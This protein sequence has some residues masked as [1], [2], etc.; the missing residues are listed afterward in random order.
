M[1][2]KLT[3]KQLLAVL[4]SIS[5]VVMTALTHL[6]VMNVAAE[7]N[8]IANTRKLTSDDFNVYIDPESADVWN[9]KDGMF[10]GA[11]FAIPQSV[12]S[13][14]N[15]TIELKT[16]VAIANFQM[17]PNAT[18]KF[19]DSIAFGAGN[20]LEEAKANVLGDGFGPNG[21]S[22]LVSNPSSVLSGGWAEFKFDR[23]L[24]QK[25]INMK[26]TFSGEYFH[27]NMAGILGYDLDQLGSN[28]VKPDSAKSS[29]YGSN[30]SVDALISE[31]GGG[32]AESA[33][34]QLEFDF[35]KVVNIN[36]VHLDFWTNYEGVP[37]DYV[38]YTSNNGTDYTKAA[39]LLG[40]RPVQPAE[41]GITLSFD[42]VQ[43]QYLKLELA[44]PSDG[45]SNVN[46]TKVRFYGGTG[47]PIIPPTEVKARKLTSADFELTASTNTW[48]VS[49]LVDSTGWWLASGVENVDFTIHLKKNIAVTK[50]K[51]TNGMDHSFPTQIQ[52]NVGYDA[53]CTGA[54]GY[55]MPK[56]PDE[57]NGSATISNTL[58]AAGY[59]YNFSTPVA[60]P[61]INLYMMNC[62]NSGGYGTA[63][64][65]SFELYGYDI[66]DVAGETVT[67]Y[68]ATADHVDSNF[69]AQNLLTGSSMFSSGS[70]GDNTVNID[71]D[72]AKSISLVGLKLIGRGDYVHFPT[73]YQLYVSDNGVDYVAAGGAYLGYKQL[74]P[75]TNM[76]TQI[77]FKETINTRYLRVK[78]SN[79][80]SS[81]NT[82]DLVKAEFYQAVSDTSSHDRIENTHISVSGDATAEH[83]L[84]NLL[85]GDINS[86]WSSTEGSEEKIFDLALDGQYVIYDVLLT[87]EAAAFPK[88]IK[89]QYK[90]SEDEDYSNVK[91]DAAFE[92]ISGPLKGVAKAFKFTYKSRPT[93]VAAKYLR[94]IVSGG[95]DGETAVNYL[96]ELEL[97]GYPLTVA[98][99]SKIPVASCVAE[100]SSQPEFNGDKLI[101]GSTGNFWESGQ[102]PSVQPTLTFK[103]D[104]RYHV[105]AIRLFGR[106]DFYGFAEKIKVQ[107]STD[108]KKF[109]D[110]PGAEYDLIQH[111][112]DAI[113]VTILLP[114]DEASQKL[115]DTT[116][117]RIV[118]LT[119]STRDSCAQFTEVELYGTESTTETPVTSEGVDVRKITASS[120]KDGTSL[121]GL[122]DADLSTYWS[123]ADG[124]VKPSVTYL[125][126]GYH[127]LSSLKIYARDGGS[128]A[129]FS[130]NYLIEYSLDGGETFVEAS[131]TKTEGANVVTLN[132]NFRA[133][134]IRITV[135]DETAAA[136]EIGDIALKGGLSADQRK[137]YNGD[138]FL[139]DSIDG[140]EYET[141]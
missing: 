3:G 99:D 106:G 58:S 128:A 137:P 76:P 123:S 40:Y 88:N 114:T 45:R 78:A 33:P 27:L 89:F 65:N 15:I 21:G 35:G 126:E 71:F 13:T 118:V 46:L 29:R 47:D 25:F 63:Q 37:V 133:N 30:S 107:A 124:S 74:Q 80:S 26:I 39:T 28:Q 97:Y 56:G 23:T 64:I 50:M 119:I 141:N 98:S 102:N 112:P 84:T 54:D 24:T 7:T 72:F 105:S 113:P 139:G 49:G 87:G 68:T 83:P 69:P 131:L 60:F 116:Y 136:W 101:D 94:V 77:A 125:F 22:G 70:T 130:K 103:L 11:D 9:K 134:A 132:G 108:G 43:T 140:N 61:Y 59:E 127:E 95:V 62:K 14:F 82:I 67:N 53:N 41:K 5:L 115:L 104:G 32:W 96:S 6:S 110:I 19:C 73:D 36:S 121:A 18:N 57:A 120:I 44:S 117:I 109:T 48:P 2:A 122:S 138:Q 66:D 34:A 4:M 20:T 135:A 10:T 55:K 12:T 93:P 129:Q 31:N 92:N 17:N 38:V 51:M 42:E 8:K 1:K 100:P 91:L 90:Q 16:D 86:Y 52:F 75:A 111:Q 81:N 85:D 79:S